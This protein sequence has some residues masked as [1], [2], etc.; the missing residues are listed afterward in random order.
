[1][2]KSLQYGRKIGDR[3]GPKK[4]GYHL[5]TALEVQSSGANFQ[6]ILMGLQ[7]PFYTQAKGVK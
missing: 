5:W 1:M 4:I 3:G 2:D 7:K 6:K